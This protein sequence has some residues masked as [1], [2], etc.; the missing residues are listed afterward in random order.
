M[1]LP[2]RTPRSTA[3]KLAIL[4]AATLALTMALSLVVITEA[5]TPA[6]AGT[7]EDEASF[8]TLINRSRADAG[9]ASLAADSAAANVARAWS[10]QMANAG[11]ISHNPSLAAEV[12][13]W[14]TTQ[15]T[16]IGE[17]VGVG[18]GVASLHDAFMASTGHRANI[19]GDYNRVGVGVVQASGRMWVTVVFIKGPAL[20]QGNQPIGA[21]EVASP[22]PGVVRVGGWALDRD[23]ANPIEVHVYIGNGGTNLGPT[24]V[25]RPDVQ[26]AVAGANATTGFDT[27]L[28]VAPGWYWVCAYAINVGG[29]SNQ[30]IGCKLLV[31]PT[32][33]FGSF[34]GAVQVPGGLRVQGWAI[35]P[36]TDQP[37]E[38]HVYVGAGGVNLGQ[39]TT[40]RPDVASS[41]PGF[42]AGHG[43]DAFVP[44]GP[45][46]HD[47]CAYGI[48]RGWGSN[49]LLGCK[50]SFID[51]E[52]IG[53]LDAVAVTNRSLQ[54]AGWA[55][56]REV[57]DPIEVHVYVD[58]VGVNLGVTSTL[59]PDVETYYPAYGQ[60]RGFVAAI[61]TSSGTHRVCA[62]GIN[63]GWG[64]NRLLGCKTVV[65]P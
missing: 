3:R 22:R 61:P 2:V 8:V 46:W 50:R 5:T 49:T 53:S 51:P 41:F 33:P 14:V 26:G 27:T 30:Q 23:S 17:N 28:A 63:V 31:V 6:A 21:L 52:P 34:D 55:M 24:S 16:R 37:I 9:K 20:P 65:V 60:Q 13:T 47:V 56:D 59:R 54:V 43:F 36:E 11:Q 10:Q 62:Y 64:A 4:V 35:D 58:G 39:A 38:V 15:W 25:S 42:S 45:G 57:M 40:S 32:D 44:V 1:S 12:S 48:N 19:L 18:Y 7:A 29:G